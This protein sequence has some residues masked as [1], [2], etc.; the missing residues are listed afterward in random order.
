LHAK[1][2]QPVASVN[3]AELTDQVALGFGGC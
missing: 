3:G 2:S 1:L